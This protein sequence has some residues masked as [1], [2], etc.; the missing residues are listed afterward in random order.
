[1]E[2]DTLSWK[3]CLV[4]ASLQAE[5]L[6]TPGVRKAPSAGAAT[7]SFDIVP[8]IWFVNIGFLVLI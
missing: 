5:P 6:A 4:T 3:Y 2:V 7:L 1:M 8:L